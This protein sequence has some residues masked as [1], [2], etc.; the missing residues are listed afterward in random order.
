MLLLLVLKNGVVNGLKSYPN[1]KHASAQKNPWRR[2]GSNES[3]LETK[4]DEASVLAGPG[5]CEFYFNLFLLTV[6]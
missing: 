4:F 1:C 2:A 3:P 5:F 6:Q